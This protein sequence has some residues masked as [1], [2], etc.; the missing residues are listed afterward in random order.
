[1]EF[2]SGIEWVLVNGVVTVEHGKHTGATAGKV[3]KGAGW[4]EQGK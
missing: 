1:M 2:P 4:R 3:L